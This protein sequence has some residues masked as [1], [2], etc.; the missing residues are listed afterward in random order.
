MRVSEIVLRKDFLEQKLRGIENYIL[1]LKNQGS[2]DKGELYSKAMQLQ[3]DLLSKIR[4][5]KI[6]L[7]N[8][9]R[10][11]IIVVGEKELSVYEAVYILKTL[12]RKIDTLDAVASASA[13]GYIDIH[14]IYRQ[15]DSLVEEYI[16]LKTR[17]Q[18]SDIITEWN[19]D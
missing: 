11:T 13:E 17:I 9:N 7:D 2:S 14:S 5:H 1:S 12:K 19:K 15:K 3:F 18:E 6:L 16:M 4:S 10:E 8:I